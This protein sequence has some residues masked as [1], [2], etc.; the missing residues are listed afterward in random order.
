MRRGLGLQT[1]CPHQ[2]DGAK[3]AQRSRGEVSAGATWGDR[4]IEGGGRGAQAHMMQWMAKQDPCAPRASL[5]HAK[6]RGWGET[7]K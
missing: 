1:V 4:T 6:G 3:A 5:P 2:A 7:G